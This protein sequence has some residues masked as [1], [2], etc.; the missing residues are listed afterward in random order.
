MHEQEKSDQ[1]T[2]TLDNPR[3]RLE[4]NHS[5]SLN[6]LTNL[7]PELSGRLLSAYVGRPDC[8]L[9]SNPPAAMAGGSD[10]IKTQF[11]KTPE[12]IENTG[13]S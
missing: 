4:V 11:Q 13:V 5:S 9:K 8:D 2:T 12:S 3:T 1:T 7:V 10:L 6:Y